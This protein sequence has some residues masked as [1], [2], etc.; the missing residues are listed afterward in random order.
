M[1]PTIWDEST[2]QQQGASQ[3]TKIVQLNPLL[4]YLDIVRAPLLERT[5]K[6]T[7]GWWSSC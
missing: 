4:H 7:T 1:T 5:R 2:L 6:C 3:Y